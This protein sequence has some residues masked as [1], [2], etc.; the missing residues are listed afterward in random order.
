M[1]VAF[2]VHFD[3]YH[4]HTHTHNAVSHGLKMKFMKYIPETS[5]GF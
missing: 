1:K 4:K 2:W 3:M 5:F